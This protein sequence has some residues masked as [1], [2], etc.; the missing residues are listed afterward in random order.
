[1]MQ[2]LRVLGDSKNGGDSLLERVRILE[3]SR[4]GVREGTREKRRSDDAPEKMSALSA[5]PRVE[6]NL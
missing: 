6:V 4:D 3:R 2:I 5:P 1:M